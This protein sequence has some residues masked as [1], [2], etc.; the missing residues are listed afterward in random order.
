[1]RLTMN[2]VST[3]WPYW[4][5]IWKNIGRRYGVAEC[6]LMIYCRSNS[7]DFHQ[8]WPKQIGWHQLYK[9]FG[10]YGLF[11]EQTQKTFRTMQLIFVL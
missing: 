5:E 2:K 7:K 11:N 6:W 4:E 9:I 8:F 3:N 10:H 1:M